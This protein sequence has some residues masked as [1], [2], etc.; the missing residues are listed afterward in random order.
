ML[1][2]LGPLHAGSHGPAD[3]PLPSGLGLHCPAAVSAP[4]RGEWHIVEW[5]HA[6]WSLP[7]CGYLHVQGYFCSQP[8]VL[9]AKRWVTQLSKKG[10][11]KMSTVSQRKSLSASHL[12]LPPIPPITP[13]SLVWWCVAF[14]SESCAAPQPLVHLQPPPRPY[15]WRFHF[16]ISAAQGELRQ[17]ERNSAAP[18]VAPVPPPPRHPLMS[19][20]SWQGQQPL[21]QHLQ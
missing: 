11:S 7:R 6:S 12:T 5:G 8:D 10:R 19:P 15:S 18:T 4:G 13:W 14:C 21:L 16:C 17:R 20:R 9:A 3:Q 2:V 1:L